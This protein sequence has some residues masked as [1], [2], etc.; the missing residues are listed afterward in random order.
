MIS[1]AGCDDDTRAVS[2]PLRAAHA[3]DIRL[4]ISL[5]IV[6]FQGDLRTLFCYLEEL[7]KLREVLDV[8][9]TNGFD[10]VFLVRYP[11]FSSYQSI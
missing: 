7:T 1:L 6:W 8:H 10:T 11:K 9:L 3:E 4:S 5:S 2:S